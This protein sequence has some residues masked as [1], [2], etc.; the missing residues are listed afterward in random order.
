MAGDSPDLFLLH[1]LRRLATPRMELIGREAVATSHQKGKSLEMAVHALESV[2]LRHSPGY[3]E[4]TFRI[5]GQKIIKSTGGV[6]YEIDI[7]VD[8]EAGERGSETVIFECKNR[9]AKVDKNDIIIFAE[10]IKVAQAWVGFFIAK[11]FTR[12]AKAQAKGEPRIQLLLVRELPIEEVPV[13][14]QCFHGI[15]EVDGSRQ[16]ACHVIHDFENGSVTGVDLSTASFT[17]D[18]EGQELSAYLR[19]WVDEEFKKRAN[20]F[21]SEFLVDGV[22]PLA[23]EASRIFSGRAVT[24]NRESVE[25]MIISGSVEMRVRRGVIVSRFDV[26]RR[27]RSIQCLVEFPNGASC[28]MHGWELR[29]EPRVLADRKADSDSAA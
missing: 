10:K 19:C 27:G 6:H 11:S 24:V 13:P 1:S 15:E 5:V 4:R 14:I 26:E 9:K 16:S 29:T 8:V 17:I 23:F 18:G 21:R 7:W 25:R 28:L 20:S 12:D 22:Y 3:D 2:I